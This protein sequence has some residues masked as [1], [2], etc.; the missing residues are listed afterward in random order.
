MDMDA[1]RYMTN[2]TDSLEAQ[3]C[4]QLADAV[5]E[6]RKRITELE[7]RAIRRLEMVEEAV[8]STPAPEPEKVTMSGPAFKQSLELL[9]LIARTS[10]DE[11]TVN[12]IGHAIRML[13]GEEAPVPF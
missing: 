7:T 4:Y 11:L 6:L 13:R 12:R 10:D 9:E 8:F 5:D 2:T 1:I 3:A